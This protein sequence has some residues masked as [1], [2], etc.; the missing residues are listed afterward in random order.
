MTNQEYL[1]IP[2][3]P[4]NP[5][6][7]AA[8]LVQGKKMKSVILGDYQGQ[9]RTGQPITTEYLGTSKQHPLDPPSQFDLIRNCTMKPEKEKRYNAG[10]YHFEDI[11][12]LV[13]DSFLG[14]R[15]LQSMS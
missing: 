3:D 8:R 14:L 10:V 1:L 12:V 4:L 11:L 2:P 6:L 5:P 9:F 13:L 7:L 15:D